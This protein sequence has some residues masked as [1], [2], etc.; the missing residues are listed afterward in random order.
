MAQVAVKVYQDMLRSDG[1][2]QHET[3]PDTPSSTEA[4]RLR[5]RS[6]K[7]WLALGLA[8]RDLVTDAAGPAPTEE[9]LKQVM[10]EELRRG[11]LERL[12]RII[13]TLQRWLNLFALFLS[14][15]FFFEFPNNLRHLCTTMPWSI[16]PALVVLWGV[17]WMFYSQEADRRDLQAF[18]SLPGHPQVNVPPLTVETSTHAVPVTGPA[19]GDWNVID[20]QTNDH[21]RPDWTDPMMLSPASFTPHAQS[22][23][24]Q[25]SGSSPPA[26]N[27]FSAISTPEQV[28]QATMA[29]PIQP[30]AGAAALGLQ[31]LEPSPSSRPAQ[32]AKSPSAP[33]PIGTPLTPPLGSAGPVNL[34]RTEEAGVFKCPIPGCKSK[35]FRSEKEAK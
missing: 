25:W 7:V 27:M 2:G 26:V 13:Q 5:Q 28:S 4:S 10:L 6:G 24:G 17:C 33:I 8:G 19:L 12:D 31:S 18:E 9:E 15:A 34:V 29:L 21:Q 16:W 35:P 20:I 30:T 23:V 14:R 32:E 3:P 22:A 11:F 1:P